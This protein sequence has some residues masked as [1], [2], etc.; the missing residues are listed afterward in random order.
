MKVAFCKNVY[1]IVKLNIMPVKDLELIMGHS[2]T[3]F[4]WPRKCLLGEY[5]EGTFAFANVLFYF[6]LFVTDLGERF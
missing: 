5:I 1:F 6:H 3:L 2:K 4:F